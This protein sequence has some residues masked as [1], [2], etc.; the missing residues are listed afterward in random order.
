MS[1]S[2]QYN[3]FLVLDDSCCLLMSIK[4]L[5]LEKVTD[6]RHDEGTFTMHRF[7]EADEE[8]FIIIMIMLVCDIV[9]EL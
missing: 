6:R 4:T 2:V 3:D 1:S 9:F 5:V 8:E 7:L